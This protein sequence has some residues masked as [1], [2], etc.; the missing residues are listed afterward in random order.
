MISDLGIYNDC[1]RNACRVPDAVQQF[2]GVTSLLGPLL[3]EARE[4][5]F[6]PAK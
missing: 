4:K 2:N 6:A 1:E 5:C 3:R